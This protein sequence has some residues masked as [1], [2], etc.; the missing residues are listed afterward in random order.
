MGL[1]SGFH[2]FCIGLRVLVIASLVAASFGC[3]VGLASADDNAMPTKPVSVTLTDAP[4]RTALTML[5][6][7]V[8]ANYTIDPSVKGTVTVNLQNVPFNVALRA[9]LKACSPPLQSSVGVGGVISISTKDAQPPDNA[10]NDGQ[11]ASRQ[12]NAVQQAG[13]LRPPG[14][15]QIVVVTGQNELLAGTEGQSPVDYEVIKLKY[16]DATTIASVFGPLPGQA[17]TII[18]PATLLEGA[19]SGST[20]S[21]NSPVDSGTVRRSGSVGISGLNSLSGST[22]ASGM[23]TM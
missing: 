16:A 7:G 4:V 22:P 5:F 6:K 14:V 18:V 10:T 19:G 12:G 21:V 17:P 9:V 8:N 15:N 2:K 20:P 11:V 1:T 23:P 13:S 3:A